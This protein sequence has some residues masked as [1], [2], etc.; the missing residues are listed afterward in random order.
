MNFG[1]ASR[2]GSSGNPAAFGMLPLLVRLNDSLTVRGVKAY[3]VGGLIRDWL[4]GRETADI[5][6]VLDAD[7]LE[8][9]P[10]LADDMGG[11]FVPL[12]KEN[13][14]ARIVLTDNEPS[15][16]PG[17]W[18]VDFSTCAGSIEQDLARRDFTVDAMA[19]ELGR[20]VDYL[21]SL[22]PL[23]SR[24]KYE[25]SGTPP[26]LVDPFH[27]VRDLRRRVLRVV[28]EDVFTADAA[29]LLRAVRLAT[30]LEFVVDE[31]VETLI[32][33]DSHLIAGVAGERVRD[34]LL[35]LLATPQTE[36][37]LL[38]L[39][40]LG[41]LTAVFP[42]VAGMKGVG[43]PEEH[44]WDVFYHSLKVVAA[45]DFLLRQGTWEYASAA[46]L[47]AVPWS[48][49][50]AQ[51]FEMGVSRGSTRMQLLKLAALLH[52]IA[53]P[54]TR[55]V[56]EGGRVR[57]LGHALE[58]AVIVTNTLERLRFSGREVK[59]VET[60]VRHHLRPTQMSQEGLPSHR[61]VY[62][63]FRDTG[64]AGIDVLFLSLA[65]HL[66]TRG[67]DLDMANWREHAGVVEYVLS[68]YFAREN[69]VRPPKLVDGHDL[70]N[71][72]AMKPGP[73][74]GV[75]LEVVREAQAAGELSSREDALSFIKDY[76]IRSMMPKE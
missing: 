24:K 50:L 59:L 67:P 3:V 33:R 64:E 9:V 32:Q 1:E 48:A 20:M 39:D 41:L 2:T 60:L 42:E 73:E 75:I 61:A 45:V 70:I 19:V 28:S 63:Y 25:A 21:Q 54:Q 71:I 8:V 72:F 53:K 57:F 4:L 37:V 44:H 30:E 18:E 23:D 40:K 43:Q 62:R 12:D 36:R 49:V 35:R 69:V 16:D 46:V 13:R 5:D 10:R 65:D 34:E 68:R 76:Q 7:A 15:A 31:P 47:S 26:G 17:W 52:D 6:I 22:A 29:R 74:I 66:A 27:G 51:H 58:G 14:V 11:K 38:Y 56:V 55:A